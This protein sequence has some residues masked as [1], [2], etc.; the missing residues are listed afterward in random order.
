M[1]YPLRHAKHA[2]PPPPPR[3]QRIRWLQMGRRADQVRRL[4]SR[5]AF[6][7]L[8]LYFTKSFTR[9]RSSHRCPVARTRC[10]SPL[11]MHPL[12]VCGQ[13]VSCESSIRNSQR[14]D[15]PNFT[16]AIYNTPKRRS[17]YRSA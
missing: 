14:L 9:R 6:L 1:V 4:V 13:P 3:S 2:C 17:S 10:D 15:V 5:T 11:L 16:T 12:F 7:Y 8:H